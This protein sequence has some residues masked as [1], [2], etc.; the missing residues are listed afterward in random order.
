LIRALSLDDLQFSGLKR[1]AE[2][3]AIKLEQRAAAGTLADASR[4]RLTFGASASCPTPMTA[5]WRP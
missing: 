1:D 3:A 2:R 4:G 5:P